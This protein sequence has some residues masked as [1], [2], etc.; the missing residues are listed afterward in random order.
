MPL[1]RPGPRRRA[2]RLAGGGLGVAGPLARRWA[3]RVAGLTLSARFLSANTWLGCSRRRPR[4]RHRSRPPGRPA[5]SRLRTL[6]RLHR[7]SAH[8][9][10]SSNDDRAHAAAARRRRAGAPAHR[11][12][13]HRVVVSARLPPRRT[14]RSW[15]R[16]SVLDV[17]GDHVV[18][19]D[20][21]EHRRAG[22]PREP[23]SC[24]VPAEPDRRGGSRDRRHGR[25]ARARRRGTRLPARPQDAPRAAASDA[26]TIMDCCGHRQALSQSRAAARGG[27]RAAR[28]PHARAVADAHR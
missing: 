25:G 18:T 28:G 26:D 13:A 14:T 9:G 8:A 27:A 6:G 10:R 21:A 2:C 4:G 12:A 15:C 7:L 24:A 20:P 5:T 1:S 19:R 3:P 17:D 16:P 23:S 22:V 11:S